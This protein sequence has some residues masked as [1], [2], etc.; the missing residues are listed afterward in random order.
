[1]D[2]KLELTHRGPRQLVSRVTQRYPTRNQDL[3]IDDPRQI[4][5][6]AWHAFRFKGE[7]SGLAVPVFRSLAPR[8][9][10][11]DMPTNAASWPVFSRRLADVVA[12]H[13]ICAPVVISFGR[14]K[15]TADYCLC[16]PKVTV[17]GLDRSLTEWKSNPFQPGKKAVETPVLRRD[18]DWPPFFRLEELEHLVFVNEKTASQIESMGFSG[19][20][21]EVPIMHP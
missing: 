21:F 10:L 14:E 13:A 6:D 3:E 9:E 20:G 1:M 4:P 15:E 2:R 16:V 7:T 17:D 18:I 12:D 11:P 8:Q 5:M 19:I